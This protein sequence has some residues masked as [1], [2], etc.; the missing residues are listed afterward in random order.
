MFA[1][2]RVGDDIGHSAA[3][4]GMMAGTVV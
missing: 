3:L 4:A 1:A 2:A